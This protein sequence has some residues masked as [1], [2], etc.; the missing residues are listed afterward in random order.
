MDMESYSQ[1]S[2]FLE[3]KSIFQKY[4]TGIK[5]HRDFFA[6][7]FNVA[8]VKEK[9]KAF[10]DTSL[11]DKILSEKFKL[12]DTNVWKLKDQRSRAVLSKLYDNITKITYRPFDD[13][14][15]CFDNSVIELLRK[16]V[17]TEF[18]DGSNIGLLLS[19]QQAETGFQHIFCTQQISEWCAVF[20]IKQEK[21]H[22]SLSPLSLRREHGRD[23]N[24]SQLSTRFH[25]EP[26]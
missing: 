3:I 17:M 7:N 15:T 9:L 10:C 22:L 25:P 11:P 8:G 23:K 16:D 4:S 18:L 19:Q 20:Q 2:S 14:F 21:L 13:R 24:Q 5:T 26:R 12:K 6:I 1:Y